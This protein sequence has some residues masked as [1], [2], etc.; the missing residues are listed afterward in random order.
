MPRES[1]PLPRVSLLCGS[2][3]DSIIVCSHDALGL[4]MLPGRLLI[5]DDLKLFGSKCN[6]LLFRVI[7]KEMCQEGAKI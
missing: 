4:Y 3:V 5:A 2:I 6:Q 1:Q 7:K